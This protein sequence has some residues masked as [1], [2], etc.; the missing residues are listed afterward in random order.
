M[1]N[2]TNT[3]SYGLERTVGL[4]VISMLLS[5]AQANNQDLL[6]AAN[7]EVNKQY[8]R[9]EFGKFQNKP[10]DANDSRRKLLIIGDSQAQDFVNSAMEHQFLKDYQVRTR[11]IPTKCQPFLGDFAQS[12]IENK[13]RAFCESVET[14][15]KSQKQIGNA[16]V[17]ILAALWRDW[18]A[19]Q[20]PQTINNLNL[21]ES[22]KL[23]VLGRKSFGK[24]SL[25]HY[26]RMS[27]DK[28][29]MLRNPINEKF[30]TVNQ[31]M[32]Q[33]LPEVTFVDQYALICGEG[34]STCPV[35]TPTGELISFDGGHLTKQGASFV[36]ERIFTSAALAQ[37][38]E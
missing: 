33:G 10:F 11:H 36:G 16:D 19:L 30:L 24:I 8:V 14:L 20:L 17:L 25:R 23:V 27:K 35:F 18:S 34:Q 3:S 12:G 2:Q 38:K 29:K 1:K 37:L 31:Q 6:K 4:F 7:P 13:D 9:A 22:Q 5:T 26:L 32:K 28:R 21:A 15:S